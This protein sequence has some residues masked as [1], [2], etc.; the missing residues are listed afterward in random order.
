[1]C[2][3]IGAKKGAVPESTA[4]VQGGNAQECDTGFAEGNVDAA[5]HNMLPQRGNV[6]P[7]TPNFCAAM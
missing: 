7:S 1:M 3:T 4:Q 5:M 6:K 2:G